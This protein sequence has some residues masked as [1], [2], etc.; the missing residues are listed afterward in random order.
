[1]IDKNTKIMI[2]IPCMEQIPVDTVQSLEALFRVGQTQVVFLPGSLVYHARNQLMEVAIKNKSDYVL[3]ID[4]DM[5]FN[6]DLLC[7]LLSKMDKMS[8]CDMLVPICFRR[9][10][11]Y[12]PVIYS[13]LQMG[14][15]PDENNIKEYLDYPRNEVFEVEGAGFGCALIKTEAMKA[16]KEKY[17][18]GFNPIAGFGEDLSFCIRLRSLGKHIYCDSSVKVGHIGKLIVGEDTYDAYRER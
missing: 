12:T 1:M 8:D 18:A 4:S 14:L 11:P 7:E 6:A 13:A 17:N 10:P 3:W 9:K 5:T 16:V 2:A 15:T